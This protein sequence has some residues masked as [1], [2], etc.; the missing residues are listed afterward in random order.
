MEIRDGRLRALLFDLLNAMLPGLHVPKFD[1]AVGVVVVRH[2]ITVRPRL[3]P[4]QLQLLSFQVRFLVV[5]LALRQF[6]R[7]A[8]VDEEGDV[9]LRVLLI[10]VHV[11]DVELNLRLVEVLVARPAA[12]EVRLQELV[13]VSEVHVGEALVVVDVEEQEDTGAV[14]GE[15]MLPLQPSSI[16]LELQPTILVIVELCAYIELQRRCVVGFPD[17]R[18]KADNLFFGHIAGPHCEITCSPLVRGVVPIEV[19]GD[20]WLL[21]IQVELRED[22]NLVV[23]ARVHR[24]RQVELLQIVLCHPQKHLLLVRAELPADLDRGVVLGAVVVLEE[25]ADGSCDIERLR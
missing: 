12:R 3:G 9:E 19:R 6:Y 16:D 2:P 15:A 23:H 7:H 17:V 5:G 10:P 18:S 1:L 25:V 20:F 22:N 11:P 8:S 13:A 14:V 21:S 4:R 24:A